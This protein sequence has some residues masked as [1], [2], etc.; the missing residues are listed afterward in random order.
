MSAPPTRVTCVTGVGAITHP[1]DEARASIAVPEVGQIVSVRGANWAVTDVQQ[2]GLAR[3]SADDAVQQLQHAVTPAVRRGRPPRRRAAGRL[4]ARA[5]AQRCKPQQRLPTDDRP[6]QVRRPEPARRLHRRPAL[7]CDHQRRRHRP[8]R[9]RSAAAPTSRPT[10]SSRSGAR[11]RS[12]RANLLLADDVGLGKTI[13]AGLVIQELFLRHRARTAIVV[14]PAGL[15]LKW[16]DEMAGEVRPRLRDRQLRDDEAGPSRP[17]H[18][19]Q[20]VHALPADHR[21]DG[22]A[23]RVSAPSASSATRCRASTRHRTRF[24]FDILV[25][26]EAHHVAPSSPTRTDKVGMERRG[27]RRRLPAHPGRP[28]ARRAGRAP[29]LPL[30]PPRT[31]A[32]PSRS[33]RCWR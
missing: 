12:P 11:L 14:C 19:R 3:S 6:G 20:P 32:T 4:G 30:A 5:G 10:S 17:R 9:R 27:L 21:V 33:P 7:G 23:A 28:R 24:A 16:Q 1:Q 2:Q 25:V 22:M 13:E 18:P 15:C 26:D 29:P 8:S 31:T